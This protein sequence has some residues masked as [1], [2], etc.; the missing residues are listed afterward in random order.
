MPTHCI[1]S[2]VSR[3]TTWRAFTLFRREKDPRFVSQAAD[4]LLGGF[5]SQILTIRITISKDSTFDRVR[6]QIDREFRH[7]PNPLDEYRRLI[8]NRLVRSKLTGL[9]IFGS[10]SGS[11][12]RLAIL[13]AGDP[14]SGT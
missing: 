4:E 11:T 10:D 8:V 6:D 2:E 14:Q 1:S 9:T 7:K 13:N 3:V 5:W 12:L